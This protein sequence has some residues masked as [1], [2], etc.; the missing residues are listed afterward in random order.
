MLTIIG[1]LFIFLGSLGS[2][3]M[4]IGFFHEIEIPKELEK[5]EL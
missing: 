3:Q 5:T 4:C 1:K 2:K